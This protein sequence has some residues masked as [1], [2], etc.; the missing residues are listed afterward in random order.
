[1][2]QKTNIEVWKAFINGDQN[3]MMDLYQLNY[4]GL[5]NY[6]HHILPDRDQLND[7]LMQMLLNLW[8]KRSRL[9][10]I[11]N[12]RSYLMTCFRRFILNR[13]KQEVWED[14]Y[15]KPIDMEQNTEISY[16]DQLIQLQK[17]NDLKSKLHRGMAKLTARQRELLQL[18]FFEDFSYDEI[19][20]QCDISKRTA[21][22][23]VHD[24]LKILR[25]ELSDG[26]NQISFYQ[27][28]IILYAFSALFEVYQ[29]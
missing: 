29:K 1:M 9:P 4:V 8:E 15:E 12:V 25:T 27:L 7:H 10:E 17:D 24:A 20:K 16:E 23:I 22:N 6:G 13:R 28:G 3:A 11:E 21:Y 19:A 5:L 26:E 18:K 2:P 14:L